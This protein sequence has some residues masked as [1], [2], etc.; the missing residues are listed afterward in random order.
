VGLQ[1][2]P[3]LPDGEL[4]Y[5]VGEVGQGNAAA[6]REAQ[7]QVGGER[8]VA[9]IAIPLTHHRHGGSAKVTQTVRC[10]GV[11]GRRVA[12][13][14]GT[15]RML[16]QIPGL[17]SQHLPCCGTCFHRKGAGAHAHPMRRSLRRKVLCLAMLAVRASRVHIEGRRGE[18][19]AQN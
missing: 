8:C 5:R 9:S 7:V 2:A 12:Y 18:Y 14:E 13:E 15:P 10:H 1:G 4:I 17:A 19:G 3:P 6:K 16:L 11:A